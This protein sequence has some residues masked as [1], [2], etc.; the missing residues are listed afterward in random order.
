[1]ILKH[2][3]GVEKNKANT[4]EHEETREYGH[5]LAEP[6]VVSVTRKDNDENEDINGDPDEVVSRYVA[7]VSFEGLTHDLIGLHTKVKVDDDEDHEAV[8]YS[9]YLLHHND[10]VAEA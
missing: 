4:D 2:Y 8:Y 6:K 1:M 10:P 9:E 5:H 7:L 3:V